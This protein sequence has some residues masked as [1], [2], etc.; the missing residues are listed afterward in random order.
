MARKKC[1]GQAAF[2]LI[3]LLV[4]IAIIMVL[5]GIILVVGTRS[6]AKAR[7]ATCVNQMR[8]IGVALGMVAEHGVPKEWAHAINRWNPH[9]PLLL[10]PQGPQDGQ[11]NYGVN[12]PLAGP[13]LSVADTGAIVLLYESKR[14]GQS[15]RGDESDVDLRHLGGSNFVFLDG[16]VKWSKEIPQF[17]P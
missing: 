10:C 15:L 11:T 4:V 1:G 9:K 14:A 3:E 12:K 17:E 6:R 7:A 13:P 5:A 8:Q 2:T 16:H